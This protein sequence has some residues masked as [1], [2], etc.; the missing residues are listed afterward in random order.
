MIYDSLMHWGFRFG[1]F[2][3][4]AMLLSQRNF[5]VLVIHE[6]VVHFVRGGKLLDNID[7][8]HP[9]SSWWCPMESL[10]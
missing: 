4:I 1:L 8:E 10:I 3:S 2:S 6:L 9:I 7:H 5:H